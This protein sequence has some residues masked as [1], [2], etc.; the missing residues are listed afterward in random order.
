MGEGE[1][2]REEGRKG[3]REETPNVL[4]FFLNLLL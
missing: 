4:S 3:E 2:E 1:G